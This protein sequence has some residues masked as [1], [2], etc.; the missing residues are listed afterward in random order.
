MHGNPEPAI[1]E[2]SAKLPERIGKMIL[3]RVGAD[4]VGCKRDHVR[5]DTEEQKSVLGIIREYLPEAGQIGSHRCMET[6]IGVGSQ[7]EGL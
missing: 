4:I 2:R 1:F 5:G 7:P 6:V 3:P